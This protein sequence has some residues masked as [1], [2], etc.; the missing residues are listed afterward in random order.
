MQLKFKGSTFSHKKSTLKQCLSFDWLV[1]MLEKVKEN[2]FVGAFS[3]VLRITAV[4][5]NTSC[6]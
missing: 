2:H 6:M 5:L 1:G 3:I 4:T